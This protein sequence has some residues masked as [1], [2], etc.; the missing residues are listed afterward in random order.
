M[1]KPG[2]EAPQACRKYVEVY[3]QLFISKKVLLKLYFS[4]KFDKFSRSFEAKVKYMGKTHSKRNRDGVAKTFLRF[5]AKLADVAA[6]F[7]QKPVSS[8]LPKIL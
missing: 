8:S 1:A 6:K 5:P 2:M 7:G 3:L 4:P